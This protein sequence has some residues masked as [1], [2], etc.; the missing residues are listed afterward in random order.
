MR[1]GWRKG[2]KY[3]V[4]H[5]CHLALLM[6]FEYGGEW[7]SPSERH[8]TTLPVCLIKRDKF[9]CGWDMVIRYVS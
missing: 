2:G 1:R 6:R 4:V 5:A 3:A 7:F 8:I 9:F